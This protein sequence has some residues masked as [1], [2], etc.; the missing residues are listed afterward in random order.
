MELVDSHCHIQSIDNSEDPISKVW[1]KDPNI[2]PESVIKDAISAKVTKMVC[3]GTD[4]ED[5]EVAVNFVAEKP[6][7]F[8]SVGIH[9][10]EAKRYVDN[11]IAKEKFEQLLSQNKVVAI[12]ECGLD[13]FYNHS[14]KQSQEEILRFQLDLAVKHDLPVIFHVREAYDDF[15]PIIND[16]PNLKAVVHS[17]TDNTDNVKKAVEHGFYI[18]VNGIATFTKEA[19]QLE[20]YK[21]IPLSNLLLETDAPFLTPKPFRGTINQPKMVSVVADFLSQL[22]NEDRALLAEQTTKNAHTIFKI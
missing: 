2:T 3:V 9:P 11:K 17:F 15:W 5:S 10:H 19:E 16:Y 7:C 12:G 6:G 21:A 14:D 4:V 1:Q 13:Y 18:G 22:R 8:A 20:A